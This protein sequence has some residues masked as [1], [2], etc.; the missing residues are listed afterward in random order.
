VPLVRVDLLI[1]LAEWL[2]QM[3]AGQSGQPSGG[4]MAGG[5][6]DSCP[7][8]AA[9]DLLLEAAAILLDDDKQQGGW[10]GS[11]GRLVAWHLD[12]AALV[13]VCH[14]LAGSL[15]GPLCIPP[16]PQTS[17]P[18]PTRAPPPASRVPSPR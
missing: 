6:S 15:T 18:R 17:R 5:E 10:R 11:V 9:E 7:L 4:L 8:V 3:Q 14:L 13:P 2:M 16:P 1:E 12:G